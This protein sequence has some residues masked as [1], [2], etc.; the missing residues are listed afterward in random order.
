M[1]TLC[2]ALLDGFE[3]DPVLVRVNGREVFKQDSVKTKRQIGKAA[4]FEVNV[5]DG[6]AN[7]EVSLPLKD[8]AKTIDL[9]VS[10]D[11]FLG[12]SVTE[13]NKIKHNLSSEPFR[14]A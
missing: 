5:K 6:P 4:S 3:G 1:S 9:K 7:V 8:L 14:Y 11:V 10:G 13:N 2:I 12:V